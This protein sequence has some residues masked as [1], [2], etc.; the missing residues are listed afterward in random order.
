M[1][2]DRIQQRKVMGRLLVTHEVM[3]EWLWEEHQYLKWGWY[4]ING[5]F[6]MRWMKGC[7]K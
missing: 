2:H 4:K 3:L 6:M 7:L 5:P 1:T